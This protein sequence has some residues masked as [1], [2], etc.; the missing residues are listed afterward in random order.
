MSYDLHGTELPAEQEGIPH[1]TL[2]SSVLHRLVTDRL[3][4]E[5]HI[6]K[7]VKLLANGYQTVE[8]QA[9]RAR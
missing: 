5:D 3:V 6:R 2:I 9:S 4:D 8:E 7:A 1:Q